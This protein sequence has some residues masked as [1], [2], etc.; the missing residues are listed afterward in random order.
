MQE[1]LLLASLNEA[2]Q[3]A[4]DC[5]DSGLLTEEEDASKIRIGQS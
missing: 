2:I 1:A 4:V 5:S 3:F